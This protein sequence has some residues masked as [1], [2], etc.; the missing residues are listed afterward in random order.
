MK[1]TNFD[2][3]PGHLVDDNKINN[4]GVTNGQVIYA[5]ESGLQFIDYADKRHTYGPVLT[6]IY[7][8]SNGFVNF[9]TTTLD[10]TLEVIK[11]NGL[12]VDGQILKIGDSFYKYRQITNNK[13][14][15]IVQ[16]DDSQINIED[17][18]IGYVLYLPDHVQGDIVNANLLISIHNTEIGN[19]LLLVKII[20]NSVDV[21][22]SRDLDGKF[23]YASSGINIEYDPSG[24]F[25]ITV[26]GSSTFKMVSY[27][28]NSTGSSK[29][30]G[31]Y[32]AA[33]D[34]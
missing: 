4:V 29:C 12:V 8:T 28:V 32:V 22:Q 20:N 26:A 1:E 30:E 7:D 34:W 10:N 19:K 25:L 27:S 15:L 16:I 6:G 3:R 2:F 24:L 31:L 13:D 9:S 11:N 21:S 5:E 23:D 17:E 33:I 18:R 14:S